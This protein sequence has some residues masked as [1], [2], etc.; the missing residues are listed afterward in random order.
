MEIVF[1]TKNH[2]V[3]AGWQTKSLYKPRNPCE[4]VDPEIDII[5]VLLSRINIRNRGKLSWQPKILI[6]L[7]LYHKCISLHDTLKVFLHSILPSQHFA[8]YLL[9]MQLNPSFQQFSF[10][11]YILKQFFENLVLGN[12]SLF[13]KYSF[14]KSKTVL[15][16]FS[17][18][19]I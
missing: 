6:F 7:I 5:K 3:D 2:Y 4:F 17:L 16:L 9:K 10:L 13:A 14:I 11:Y 8:Y 12:K 19:I 15:K 1:S 18:C